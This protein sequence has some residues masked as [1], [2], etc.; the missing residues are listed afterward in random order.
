LDMSGFSNIL[1]IDCTSNGI[2]ALDDKGFGHQ[3]AFSFAHLPDVSD[4]R[5]IIAISASATHI[6]GVTAEGRVLSLGASDMGQCETMDWVLFTPATA[7]APTD[8]PETASEP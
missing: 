8:Q 5:N 3:S 1:A 6:A 7:A 4:W 2:Y